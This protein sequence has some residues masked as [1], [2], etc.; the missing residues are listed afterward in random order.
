MTRN[1]TL[2]ARFYRATGHERRATA[3]SLLRLFGFHLI[4]SAKEFLSDVNPFEMRML[5]TV[6]LYEFCEDTT[7]YSGQ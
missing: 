5:S 1:S 2:V 7:R 4:I 3:L 6:V